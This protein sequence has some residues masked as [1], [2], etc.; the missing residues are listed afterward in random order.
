MP[1]FRIPDKVIPV[2]FNRLNTIDKEKEEEQ[3][4]QITRAID[5]VFH[6]DVYQFKNFYNWYYKDYSTKSDGGLV[7]KKSPPP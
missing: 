6:V 5:G 7:K 1:I 3:W 2:Y 4:Y